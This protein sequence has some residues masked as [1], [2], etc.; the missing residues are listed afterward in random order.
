[1]MRLI[2]FSLLIVALPAHKAHADAVGFG[3][4]DCDGNQAVRDMTLP[5][6]DMSP[7]NDLRGQID[8][9]REQR[10]A[11]SRGL[12]ALSTVSLVGVGLLRRRRRSV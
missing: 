3:G 9:R 7:P 2:L 5:P 4:C 6:P 10:R 1:M 11:G 8:A 12:I